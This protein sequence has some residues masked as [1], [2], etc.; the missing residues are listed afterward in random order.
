[1]KAITEEHAAKTTLLLVDDDRLILSTLADG[2]RAAG[3]EV[4]EAS[5]GEVA[6]RLA[7]EADPD[8]AICDVRMPG[9][10]GLE[11]APRLQGQAGVP[12]IFLSAYGDEDV[13]RLGSE[14]GALGYLVKPL[15]VPD[16]LPTI[17]TALARAAEIRKLRHT[18]EQ[19]NTALA[20]SREVSIAIGVLMERHRLNRGDAF[21]LLRSHSR[22][23]RRKLPE[24]AAELLEAVEKIN[25]IKPAGAP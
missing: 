3:F 20:N 16:M 22:S 12:F 6:L 9:M 10:S 14:H 13:V 23:K 5:S 7:L 18:E 21:E 1:M 25:H 17:R 19:L 15:N 24:V 2:L 8:L 4:L 11:L